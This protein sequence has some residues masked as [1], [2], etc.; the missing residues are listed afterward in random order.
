MSMYRVYGEGCWKVI[1]QSIPMAGHEEG[2]WNNTCVLTAIGS[3]YA[4][5]PQTCTV[6]DPST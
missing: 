2:Y 5:L 4:D 3:L 1:A 6:T